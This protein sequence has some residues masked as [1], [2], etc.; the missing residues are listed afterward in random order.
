MLLL[1]LW[2]TFHVSSLY[3]SSF[4]NR[5]RPHAISQDPHDRLHFCFLGVCTSWRSCFYVVVLVET[6]TNPCHDL[7]Q[8]DQTWAVLVS[9]ELFWCS[10]CDIYKKAEHDYTC[11]PTV[12][13]EGAL[14]CCLFVE[15]LYYL[16]RVCCFCCCPY[17][18]RTT[19]FFDLRPVM[20]H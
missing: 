1:L 10:S 20:P 6:K 5:R 7:N 11:F 13:S 3:T 19:P 17:L 2:D 15:C 8:L 16:G 14:I 18:T 9:S 12:V 4:D